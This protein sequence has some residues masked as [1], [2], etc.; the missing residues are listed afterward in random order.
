MPDFYLKKGNSLPILVVEVSD[1]NGIV[2]L[3]GV[4]LVEFIYQN[5]ETETLY[6]R[7]GT[8]VARESGL[9]RYAW[10]TGDTTG[11]GKYFGEFKMTY[12]GGSILTFPNNR[13]LEFIV[14][15]AID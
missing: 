8:M 1:D 7:T 11:V 6:T 12:S 9:I 3:S 5:R 10:T 14:T 4:S 13:Y 15:H 2:N